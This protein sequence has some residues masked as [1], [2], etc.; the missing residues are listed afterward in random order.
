MDPS[1]LQLLLIATAFLCVSVTLHRVRVAERELERLRRRRGFGPD[2][3]D[4]FGGPDP[5]VQ[6][7]AVRESLCAIRD[8]CLHASDGQ[9][10]QGAFARIARE[11]ELALAPLDPQREALPLAPSAPAPSPASSKVVD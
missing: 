6:L 1:R 5:S 7:D 10:T 8:E 2:A 4:G 9:D 11:A 3:F